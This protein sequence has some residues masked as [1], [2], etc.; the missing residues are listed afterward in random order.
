[1]FEFTRRR[2]FLDYDYVPLVRDYF[3]WINF[4]E[5]DEALD[6]AIPGEVEPVAFTPDEALDAAD[7]RERIAWPTH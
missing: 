5:E 2:R 3:P 1:M 4:D 6:T 7:D